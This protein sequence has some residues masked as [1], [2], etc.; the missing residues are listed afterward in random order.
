MPAFQVRFKG[1][2]TGAERERLEQADIAVKGKEPSL[3]IGT[4]KTG[5]SIYT[6]EVEATSAD[7][8]LQ[9]VRDA[10][11]PDTGNFSGWDAGPA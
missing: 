10:L 3:K 9:K 8:A 1:M 6:V 2:L 7:E 5:P 4:I 11:D